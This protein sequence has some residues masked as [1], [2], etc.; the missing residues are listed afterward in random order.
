MQRRA[1]AVLVAALMTGSL[2]RAA[3]GATPIGRWYA[4]GGAAQVEISACCEALCGRV[5]WLRS[6]FD[7]DGCDLR[8]GR[9][10]DPALRD[11]PLIGLQVLS[12]LRSSSDE[13]VWRGGTIYDP[14]SGR[15]YR[16]TVQLDGEHRLHIRGYIGVPLLGRTTTWIRV[17]SEKQM[18]KR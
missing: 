1:A 4:E 11:R 15:T 7:D 2:A 14:T 10:P 8:D 6:P 13:Q 12:G 3:S 16:C 5:V 17:G 9:N 18:C